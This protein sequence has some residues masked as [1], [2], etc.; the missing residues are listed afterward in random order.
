MLAFFLSSA[1]AHETGPYGLGHTVIQADIPC[2]PCLESAPCPCGVR[3][4]H[5]FE[6]ER[7]PGALVGLL[8]GRADAAG[9]RLPDG[10]QV[11]TSGLDALGGVLRLAA[12]QDAQ[13]ALRR[14]AR[15]ELAAWL[16]VAE[17]SGSEELP[18]AAEEEETVRRWLRTDSDWMLPPR[19]YS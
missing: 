15:R 2:V 12:G 9:N 16:G 11:W 1:Y 13:A 14:A 5:P 8:Q 10:L 4:L 6:D 17:L 3:C 7:L 19:R 18:A